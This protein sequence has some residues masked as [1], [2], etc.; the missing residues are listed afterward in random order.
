MSANGQDVLPS[1]IEQLAIGTGL[2]ADP[3]IG[4]SLGG[5]IEIR[6]LIGSGMAG[7]VYEA[8]Q[9]DPKRPVAVKVLN[10]GHLD[11]AVQRDLARRFADEVELLVAIEHPNVIRVHSRGGVVV[12]G[13]TFPYYVMELL[14]GYTLNQIEVCGDRRVTWP[15]RQEVTRAMTWEQAR[16]AFLQLCLGM[17]AIHALGVIH[18]DLK[19]ENI[20]VARTEGG[21]F[22]KIMDLGIAKVSRGSLLGGLT[23]IDGR[24]STQYDAVFGTP[25]TMAP[26][27]LLTG[28]GA[29]TSRTDIYAMGAV[30]YYML[31]GCYPYEGLAEE[32]AKIHDIKNL[33]AI[34]TAV[35]MRRGN[36]FLP[37]AD[38]GYVSL[39]TL[40]PSTPEHPD[41][42]DWVD[43]F[44]Y[45]CIAPNPL[46]RF[47]SVEEMVRSF[48]PS[49]GGMGLALSRPPSPVPPHT[50]D[51]TPAPLRASVEPKLPISPLR[52]MLVVGIVFIALM[53]AFVV[54]YRARM[55]HSSVPPSSLP[56]TVPILPPTPA[57]QD[58]GVATEGSAFGSVN[59]ASDASVARDAS[60]ADAFLRSR[61]RRHHRT[62]RRPD[63]LLVPDDL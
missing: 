30:L 57:I 48:S 34:W 25:Y 60:G 1:L 38:S 46:E 3:M 36:A 50:I 5:G 10:V 24:E 8:E 21:A 63:G 7:A 23:V 2:P 26:E 11:P 14:S 20:F 51:S 45:R 29:V 17:M 37:S 43:G 53:T 19:A 32:I 41:V 47:S 59:E 49:L 4:L 40:R 61:R 18:R 56:V 27:Q 16:D 13:N 15:G 39:R 9:L 42:P 33:Q 62:I 22:V 54:R 52:W 31:T 58:A 12:R 35:H 44:I 55:S 28:A 6:R